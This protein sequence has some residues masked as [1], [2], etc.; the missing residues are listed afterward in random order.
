MTGAPRHVLTQTL[1]GLPAGERAA[2]VLAPGAC[3]I[4][5]TRALDPVWLG[6][7]VVGSEQLWRTDD[8]RVL[9]T[10]WWYSASMWLQMPSLASLLVTGTALSPALSDLTLHQR[11]DLCEGATSTA[12]LAD[13]A[14]LAPSLR[15]AFARIISVLAEVGHMR[16]RP[17]W[18]LA[19]D[20]TAN[21]LLR[22]GAATGQV[23]RATS[24][25]V[26]L[27]REVG[28]PLPEPVFVRAARSETRVRRTS[29]C[30]LHLAPGLPMCRSCPKLGPAGLL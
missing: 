20:S 5:A 9:A 28:P 10:I 14:E 21:A 17:L 7:R 18:A 11:G 3:G 22:L 30:L 27:S 6:E 26:D 2:L 15:K 8:R 16:T 12:V 29:C 1:A 23:R 24:L 13:P 19:S 4:P 25:A